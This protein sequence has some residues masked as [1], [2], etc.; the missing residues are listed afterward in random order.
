[1]STRTLAAVAAASILAGTGLVA[2]ASGQSAGR[3]LEF[4]AKAPASKD[5]SQIDLK[6][7]GLS[8]GDEFLIAQTLRA[9][10]TTAGRMHVV[11]TI[12]DVSYEG[13]ECRVSLILRDG[14]LIARGAG[15][16]RN[17]PGVGDGS[18]GKGDQFAILGGTGAYAGAGGT[19]TVTTVGGAGDHLE[20]ALTE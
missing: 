5:A 9:N 8:A 19:L 10:G 15:L 14:Q 20:V 18:P 11:C 13:Q 3:T 1:M 2:S 4:T 17:L 16:D 7:R 12:V 6:P